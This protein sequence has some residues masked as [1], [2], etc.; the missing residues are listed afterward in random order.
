VLTPPTLRLAP[1]RATTRRVSVRELE[2]IE[3]DLGDFE[4]STCRAVF[5]GVE[6]VGAE[7][8]PLPIGSSLNRERGVF[9]WQPG[10]DFAGTYHLSFDV[11]QC[12]G[13]VTRINIDLSISPLDVRR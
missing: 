8:R 4:P 6:R 11:G 9:R 3:V 10:P 13:S 5:T 12:D 7:Q 2:A 1:A